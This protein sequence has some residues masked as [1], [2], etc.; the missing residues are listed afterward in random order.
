MS[1]RERQAYI[2]GVK[3]TIGAIV[4]TGMFAFIFIQFFI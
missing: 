4:T 1:K 2:E 3:T